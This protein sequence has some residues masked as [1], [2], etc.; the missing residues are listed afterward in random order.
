M[1]L[2]NEISI[3]HG[4]QDFFVK[5]NSTPVIYLPLLLIVMITAIKDGFEDLKRHKSD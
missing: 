5:V 4:F 1:Q 2:I 3:S